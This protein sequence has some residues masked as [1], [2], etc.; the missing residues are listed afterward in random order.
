MNDIVNIK[1]QYSCDAE[2][3]IVKRKD[4][5][6]PTLFWNRVY[7]TQDNISYVIEIGIDDKDKNEYSENVVFLNEN[8][9]VR[10]QGKR[11]QVP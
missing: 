6:R 2:L 7:D 3:Y 11:C 1:K 10:W 4:S 5:C 8:K 9:E